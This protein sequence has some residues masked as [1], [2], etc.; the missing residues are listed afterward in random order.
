MTV[1]ATQGRRRGQAAEQLCREVGRLVA[2]GLGDRVIAGIGVAGIEVQAL[3]G[4]QAARAVEAV[5]VAFEAQFFLHDVALVGRARAHGVAAEIDAGDAG[6]AVVGAGL[7]RVMAGHAFDRAS[8]GLFRI[9]DRVM[10]YLGAV[11]ALQKI[12]AD[13]GLRRAAVVTGVTQVLG[14]VRVAAVARQVVLLDPQAR[15]VARRLIVVGPAVRPV[16]IDA[17]P[18]LVGGV[19][20]KA[21]AVL[22][23]G[24]QCAAGR[25]EVAS[26]RNI[27][28]RVALEADI[29]DPLVEQVAVAGA[30]V[31]AARIGEVRRMAGHALDL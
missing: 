19:R 11:A 17:G 9:H 10:E 1:G 4:S 20:G 16:A 28:E 15:V 22:A 7:V 27:C 24:P 12:A 31:G 21:G 3:V 13:V 2:P 14:V 30:A 29:V 5:A 25:V 6:Q 26:A 18:L 8:R 23:A